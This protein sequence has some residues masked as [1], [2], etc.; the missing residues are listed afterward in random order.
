VREAAWP[1]IRADLGLSYTA[2]GLL[3]TVPSLLADGVEPVLAL[4]ADSRRRRGIIAAGGLAFAFALLVIAGA[5]SFAVLLA[6]FLI[7]YPASGAFVSLSQATLMDLQPEHRERNM[8]RWV[9]AGSVGLVAGPLAVAA[10]SRL[11]WGWRPLFV[12]LAVASVPLALRSR[13]AARRTTA[14]GA[15]G[16]RQTA[17]VALRALRRGPV[18]RWL[19]LVHLTDLLGDVLAGFLAVYFVDV[20]GV[21]LEQAALAVVV[22]TVA[23]LIGDALLVYVLTRISGLRYLRMTALVAVAYPGML[24]APGLGPKLVLLAILGLLHAG[25]YAVPQGRLYDELHD[26]SGAALALSNITGLAAGT[27]P[28]VIGAAAERIGLGGALW[29]CL[30]APVAL[31]AG[32]PR[33]ASEHRKAR[34]PNT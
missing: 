15:G 29:L 20:V 22:W 32:L 31:L 24:L 2:I 11:G 17:A 30:A 10:A 26:N 6:G 21:P 13:L 28:L 12:G 4:L 34:E 7:L 19:V 14:A 23:G 33:D 5:P 18:I 27:L 25:W 1:A 9:L 3:L 16:F 8:A